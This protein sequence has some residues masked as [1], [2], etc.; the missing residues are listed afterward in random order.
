MKTFNEEP[1]LIIKKARYI[2]MG[3]A[4]PDCFCRLILTER[5]LYVVEDAPGP[6]TI[7]ETVFRSQILSVQDYASHG[8]FAKTAGRGTAS[9]AIE[10]VLSVI[11]G[12]VPHFS[13]ARQAPAERYLRITCT[14]SLGRQQLLYFKD[15]AGSTKRFKKLLNAPEK[16]P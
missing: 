8:A 6:P 15:F 10:A 2:P 13:G 12:G 3:N 4:L 1:V 14:D 11:A 7:L 16:S 9:L 5:K